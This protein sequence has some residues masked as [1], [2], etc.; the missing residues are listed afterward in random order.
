MKKFVKLFRN[1]NLSLL[2]FLEENC[3]SVLAEIFSHKNKLS[4]HYIFDIMIDSSRYISYPIWINQT[5]YLN[6]KSN[7][8][9]TTQVIDPDVEEYNSEE[10]LM[11]NV[12]KL[13]MFN[14][15]LQ[16]KNKNIPLVSN[17]KNLNIIYKVLESFSQYLLFEE[18]RNEFLGKEIL[19]LF[20]TLELHRDSAD[21]MEDISG[22][23]SKIYNESR[24]EANA[25]YSNEK[26]GNFKSEKDK[27][28]GSNL[29]K[30][31]A[32]FLED[33]KSFR[34]FK[35]SINNRYDFKAP[36]KL[37]NLLSDVESHQTLVIYKKK[38]L[39]EWLMHNYDINPMIQTFLNS[40]SP[41]KNFVEIS[42]ENKIPI[43][44][45]KLLA[46]QIH[47]LNLGKIL[48]KF[49][50]STILT[51]NP[52]MKIK[53]DVENDFFKNY[54]LNLYEAL[55]NFSNL[56]GL[57]KIFKKSFNQITSEKFINLVNYLTANEYL[58][59]CNMYILPRLKLKRKYNYESILLNNSQLF[60]SHV[61]KLHVLLND[62]DVE[63][64]SIYTQ[65]KNKDASCAVTTIIGDKEVYFE[66]ALGL[67][68]IQNPEDCEILKN[69]FFLLSPEFDF[70]E[71]CYLTGYKDD[72]AY[73][74]I[75]K[76]KFLFNFIIDTEEI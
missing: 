61:D 66:D 34:L 48:K 58:I 70:D 42:L 16:F 73:K 9:N 27:D 59:Q 29:I 47:C 6:Y 64:G 12:V 24:R 10:E 5:K 2:K 69:I 63:N 62:L 45:I 23:I 44:F 11:S 17:S 72:L 30:S 41:F 18:Y 31:L 60:F 20:K 68:K 49:N 39:D 57:N 56:R 19:S 4:S 40:V 54:N 46:K 76:Y 71:I 75:K 14:L 55:N 1:I 51:V 36:T 15:V 43:E 65:N 21:Y 8:K 74:T 37:I 25:I 53:K 13:K 50:N 32:K 28:R 67:I 35:V 33:L 22:Q 26:S 38:G 7:I 3:N 52:D